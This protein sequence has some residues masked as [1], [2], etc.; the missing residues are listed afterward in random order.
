ML[1]AHRPLFRTLMFVFLLSG[2][3][4]SIT[5]EVM[6]PA[7]MSMSGMRK[8]AV[9]SLGYPDLGYG[10]ASLELIIQNMVTRV[11][12]NPIN[13]SVGQE[14]LARYATDTIVSLLANTSTLTIT[15]PAAVE[16]AINRTGKLVPTPRELGD[17]LGV[18]ALLFGSITYLDAK[19]REERYQKT[20]ARG[21]L[22][23]SAIFIK[24]AGIE[25][26]W[27]IL[28]LRTGEIIAQKTL[29]GKS[30]QTRDDYP[31]LPSD[32]AMYEELIKRI[33]TPL[34]HQ[35]APHKKT[36]TR[37]L[38]ADETKNPDM[39]KLNELVAK[40]SYQAALDGFLKIWKDLRNVAAGYNAAI[41]FEITGSMDAAISLMQE[42]AGATKDDRAARELERLQ[43]T[44]AEMN[45]AAAQ[46]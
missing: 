37:L 24:R 34:P 16:A 12:M 13:R 43:K 4:T 2:C 22:Y 39:V 42:V 46:M 38:L 40:K 44:K 21:N 25:L 30:E 31:I 45:A 28:N 33:L 17:T 36:E 18:D 32:S 26:R 27:H 20:D 10:D 3:T 11:R 7:E 23:E 41:L 9:L 8:I 35:L 14:D 5:V 19:V 29:T 1:T 6:K 15:D